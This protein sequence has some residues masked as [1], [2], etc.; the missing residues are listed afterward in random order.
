MMISLTPRDVRVLKMP[1]PYFLGFS[2]GGAIG[3]K[4]RVGLEMANRTAPPPGEGEDLK[5]GL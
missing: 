5:E 2:G 4:R 1:A 3:R